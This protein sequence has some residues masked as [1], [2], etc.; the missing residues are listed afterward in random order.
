MRIWLELAANAARGRQPHTAVTAAITQEFSAWLDCHLE[1][2]ADGHR[3]STN[4][5]LLATV[6]G[7]LFLDAIGR[8]DLADAALY[9][10][11]G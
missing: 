5:L 7:L 3:G 9:G 10:L 2:P 8:R 1:P 11:E 6:E 4:A